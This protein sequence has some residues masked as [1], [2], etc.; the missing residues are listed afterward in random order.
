MLFK[1]IF[2]ILS[3]FLLINFVINIHFSKI[4]LASNHKKS[5]NDFKT[6]N[7]TKIR[8]KKIDIRRDISQIKF[9]GDVIV[10]NGDNSMLSREMIV[11]YEEENNKSLSKYSGKSSKIDRID[12]IGNVKIFSQEFVAT[13]KKGYYIPRQ[14][15]FVLIGD[16]IVNNG[17][18]IASGNKFI[19]NLITNKGNFI[20]EENHSSFSGSGGSSKSQQKDNRIIVIIGEDNLKNKDNNDEGRVNE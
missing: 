9:I 4:I 13:S 15:K 11:V 5:S 17:S 7:F 20:G 16:V 1:K 3:F 2:N 14:E 10:E 12:A 8:S 6:A 18:S 19:Y